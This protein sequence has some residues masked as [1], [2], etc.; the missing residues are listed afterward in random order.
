MAQFIQRIISSKRFPLYSGL[1]YAIS[2]IIILAM[3]KDLQNL[4]SGDGLCPDLRF[5]YTPDEVYAWAKMLGD[6][7]RTVYLK[8]CKKAGVPTTVALLFPFAM[9]GDVIETSLSGYA[10][11]RFPDR[12]DDGL[13]FA[14]SIGNQFK[15]VS[16]GLGTVTLI[17]LALYNSRCRMHN[18][19][20]KE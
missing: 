5:G 1:L 18:S 4:N 15:W 12:I 2:F 8:M 17:V 11:K 19:S 14:S 13:L 10:V 9:L 7:G 3:N 6:N 20:K 16:F